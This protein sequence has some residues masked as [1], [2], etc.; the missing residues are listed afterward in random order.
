MYDNSKTNANIKVENRQPLQADGGI[1]K[2]YTIDI[3]DFINE[4]HSFL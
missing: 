4:F 1:S 3:T 2:E